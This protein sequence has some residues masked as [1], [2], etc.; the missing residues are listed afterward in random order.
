ML[1][2]TNQGL[3]Q[4]EAEAVSCAWAALQG[5]IG[6]SLCL[7][8]S[9]NFVELAT[10][11]ALHREH[12]C[13]PLVPWYDYRKSRVGWPNAFWIRLTSAEGDTAGVIACILRHLKR[14]LRQALQDATFLF[15]DAK[16]LGASGIAESP[17][18]ELIQGNVMLPG[19]MWVHP[20]FRGLRLSKHLF[21]AAMIEGYRMWKPDHVV[22]LV[23]EPKEN[24]I[25]FASYRF[26]RAHKWYVPNV[27]GIEFT[28][29][30]EKLAVMS[31][32]QQE[33]RR[34]F[35]FGEDL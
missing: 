14:S 21:A 4:R 1:V 7:E 33:M 35:L 12:E 5:E 10:R 32:T 28:A 31:M 22:G 19:A 18:L 13:P 27:P 24:P 34:R 20:D 8:V 3:S 23:E 6:N 17:D 29:N 30:G 16:A 25:G 9:T 15:A 26:P 11:N 2:H